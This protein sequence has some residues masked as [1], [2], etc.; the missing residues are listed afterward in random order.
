[1]ENAETGL[2]KT[3]MMVVDIVVKQETDRNCL[4]ALGL[5]S[6]EICH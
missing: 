3:E 5:G 1:M 2:R 4:T 6:S